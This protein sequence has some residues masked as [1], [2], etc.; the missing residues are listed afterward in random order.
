MNTEAIWNNFSE[1]LLQFINSKTNNKDASKDILQDVFVKV[2][3]NLDKLRNQDKVSSWVYQITRNSIIDYFRKGKLNTSI[4]E[5]DIEDKLPDE[6]L[7]FSSCLNSFIKAL[8]PKDQDVLNK[9]VYGN[10]S[11][12]EYAKE[13]GIPY[14]SLKSRVQRAK[15]KLKNLFTDCC[16]LTMDS[17][18]NIID[19][20]NK[21][22]N[23]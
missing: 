16:H 2:H 11:Q 8:D 21:D 9:T 5:L 7:D 13:L 6:S 10:T 3:T 12:K 15:L 23:C 4:S 17:Y 20:K 22:C 14:S 19:A 1:D 18:G